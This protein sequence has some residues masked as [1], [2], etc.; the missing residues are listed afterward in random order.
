MPKTAQKQPPNKLEDLLPL[1]QIF[2]VNDPQPQD[3]S[4]AQKD[5]RGKL[6]EG[7]GDGVNQ[8]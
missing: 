1:D 3:S 2:D 7:Q 6:M 8:M 4:N 5:Q